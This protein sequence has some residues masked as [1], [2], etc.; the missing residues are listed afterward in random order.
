MIQI[1]DLH[2]SGLSRHV[3]RLLELIPR[4]GFTVDLQ[5]LF[6]RLV[7][8]SSTE[9]LFGES[10]A[11]LSPDAVP[12]E[13][14]NFPDTD[15]HGQIV[16]GKRFQTTT[17]EHIKLGP[18]AQEFMPRTKDVQ[19]VRNQL[20]NI[21]MP[22]HEATGVALTNVVFQIARKPIVYARL[23]KEID[24]AGGNEKPWTFECLKSLRYLQKV[25]SETFRLN[26]TIG[27]TIRV[28]LRGT[29]LA[30][31]GDPPGSKAPLYVNKGDIITF[32]LYALHRRGDLFGDDADMFRPERRETLRPSHWS[33]MPFSGG[34]RVYVGQNL[35]LI[36]VAYTIVKIVQAFKA[37]ENRDPVL[38][39]VEV[40][41]FTTDSKNGAKVAFIR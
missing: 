9:F 7:L 15:N 39:F 2:L 13:V 31:G 35:A 18:D 32:S 38:E 22:A 10:A 20:M 11:S 24:E 34:P 37:I 21:S 12:S 17:L 4:D 26:L 19:D 29:I 8:D 5:P 6:A 30:T 16:V 33:Y 23:R 1:A 27:T 14:Q 3:Q 36:E 25:I 40:Y 28:A 41:K